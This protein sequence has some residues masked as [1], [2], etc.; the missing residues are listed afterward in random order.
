MG[1]TFFSKWIFK[2]F[3]WQRDQFHWIG[4]VS[5]PYRKVLT[6]QNMIINKNGITKIRIL[7][8]IV[9]KNTEASNKT[10]TIGFNSKNPTHS[11]LRIFFLHLSTKYHSNLSKTVTC[12]TWHRITISLRKKV[13]WFGPSPRGFAWRLILTSVCGFFVRLASVDPINSPKNPGKPILGVWAFQICRIWVK[14]VKIVIKVNSLITISHGQG[15]NVGFLYWFWVNLTSWFQ[16]KIQKNSSLWISVSN[17][18]T[19]WLFV[20]FP[21]IY[22]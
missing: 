20:W 10:F 13:T 2:R 7:D 5:K 22:T 18:A 4:Q 14:C 21:K 12:T 19:I 6:H 3:P 16:K 1:Y 11:N 15:L 9:Q 8:K 17:V